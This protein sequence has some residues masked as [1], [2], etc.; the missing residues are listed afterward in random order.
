M[1]S[2]WETDTEKAPRSGALDRGT[3]TP[4]ARVTPGGPLFKQNPARSGRKG[5]GRADVSA[6]GGWRRSG[7]IILL[8][9]MVVLKLALPRLASSGR[10]RVNCC[11]SLS[12]LPWAARSLQAALSFRPMFLAA[13]S[14]RQSPQ[15]RLCRP[16]AQAG[17]EV[18]FTAL[19]RRMREPGA[20]ERQSPCRWRSEPPGARR[21]IPRRSDPSSL[22]VVFGFQLL[23]TLIARNSAGQSA[24]L[25]RPAG[26]A[27]AR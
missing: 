22:V 20:K 26:E 18:H 2:I 17:R 14:G 3:L 27:S 13:K 8:R 10:K 5:R 1:G 9:P 7:P 4:A 21:R 16:S 19:F 6:C 23:R 12:H 25:R 11:V 24:V 15:R